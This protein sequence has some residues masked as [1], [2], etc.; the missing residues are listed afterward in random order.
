VPYV[1][2]I[3]KLAPSSWLCFYVVHCNII[4][5]NKVNGSSL[6]VVYTCVLWFLYLDECYVPCFALCWLSYEILA[7]YK[8]CWD[9]LRLPL[10]M[11]LLLG[12]LGCV[13]ISCAF[14]LL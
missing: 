3:C 1:I 8:Y 7:K 2:L 10:D 9:V 11:C 4:Y 13:G 12:Q 6:G 5:I 14:N